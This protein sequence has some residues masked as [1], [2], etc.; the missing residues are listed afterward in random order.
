MPATRSRSCYNDRDCRSVETGV[1]APLWKRTVG[2]SSAQPEPDYAPLMGDQLV[3]VKD[4]P[5][6]TLEDAIKI[7]T[8]RLTQQGYR[9][10]APLPTQ[11]RVAED[12]LWRLPFRVADLIPP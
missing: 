11:P 9:E 7:A 10:I 8:H 3:E 4:F 2:V 5:G 6:L 1:P 12:G